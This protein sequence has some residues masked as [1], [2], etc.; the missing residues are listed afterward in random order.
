MNNKDD[1]W[2]RDILRR[3]GIRESYKGYWR[4]LIAVDRCLEDSSRLLAFRDNIYVY[5]A[6]QENVVWRTVEKN[7]RT[8]V[9]RAWAINPELVQEIAGYRIDWEPSVSEFISN[10][11]TYRKKQLRE[12]ELEQQELAKVPKVPEMPKVP[13]KRE[14]LEKKIHKQLQGVDIT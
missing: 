9:K 13:E 12:M 8:V 1:F 10:L 4:V 6:K 2:L 5:M 14:V 3:L 7:F 11:V